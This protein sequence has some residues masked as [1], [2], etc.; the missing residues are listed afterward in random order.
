M[1]VT[2]QVQ[3]RRMPPDY[4]VIT[5]LVML[6]PDK[7]SLSSSGTRRATT[8]RLWR[9]AGIWMVI[10]GE[11]ARQADVGW[12]CRGRSVSVFRSVREVYSLRMHAGM[13]VGC[14]F[15]HVAVGVG[16]HH[17]YNQQVGLAQAAGTGGSGEG[18]SLAYSCQFSAGTQVPS[19]VQGALEP[20]KGHPTSHARTACPCSSL[21]V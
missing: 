8:S 13:H 5:S 12:L 3:S 7:A 20:C 6:F 1:H 11:R 14:R 4:S 10:H 18:A 19:C 15:G 17:Q 9:S 2:F 21:P 16:V